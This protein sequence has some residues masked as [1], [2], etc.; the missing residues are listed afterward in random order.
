MRKWTILV[1]AAVSV[2]LIGGGAIVG[3][4]AR[5]DRAELF[6][7]FAT[8]RERRL[9]QVTGGIAKDLTGVAAAL[10]SVTRPFGAAR[11]GDERRHQ[12]GVLLAVVRPYLLIEVHDAAGQRLLS[13]TD[14]PARPGFTAEAF[15]GAMAGTAS[16]AVPLAPGTLVVSPPV[17]EDARGWFRI[18]ALAL[19]RGAAGQPTGAITALV[20]TEPFF[21]PLLPVATE[22][23][24]H[25]LVLGPAGRPL[26]LS[27]RALLPGV[28]EADLERASPW[29]RALVTEMRAGRRGTLPITGG[30]ALRAGLGP[31]PLVVAYA[32]IP[33][34]DA[35]HWSIAT[36]S[37]TATVRAD[38]R[39]AMLRLGL[40]SGLLAVCLVGLGGFILFASRRAVTLRERLCHA[41]RN[42]R[43]RIP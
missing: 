12:L 29:L 17:A 24:S 22:P 18:F 13:V 10:R 34:A 38:E 40:T 21:A 19:P 31:D 11:T 4:R 26:P 42:P 2:V 16:R 43:E 14:P 27:S 32:P 39:A 33:V 1:V 36:I 25:L 6:A 41:T 23:G 5:R 37:S 30:D 35:G 7:R 9:D 8:E 3:W 15:Q 28:G 20:D